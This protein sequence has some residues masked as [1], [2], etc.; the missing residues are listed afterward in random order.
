MKRVIGNI[1]SPEVFFLLAAPLLF[2][3]YNSKTPPLQASDEFNHFYRVWQVSEGQ[4][5][6]YKENHRLGGYVPQCVDEFSLPFWWAATNL[7]YS[8]SEADINETKKVLY[9]DTLYTFKDFPNTAMYSPVSYAPQAL[10]VYMAKKYAK[11]M[12]AIYYAGRY[13]AIVFWLVLIFLSIRLMPFG[14]WLFVLL[15][16]LPMHVYI[17]T[18][19]SADTVTNALAFFFTAY[20]LRI[21]YQKSRFTYKNLFVLALLLALLATAKVVYIAL[22]LLLL[23]VPNT[24]FKN[25]THWAMALLGLFV[26]SGLSAYYWSSAVVMKAYT[27]YVFYNPKFR[28]GVIL[29]NCANYYLQKYLITHQPAYLASVVYR[30][31]T[32]HPGTYLN[33]FIG[34]LG[35]FD[36]YL[37]KRTTEWAYY[38][39]L[40]T[41][42]FNKANVFIPLWHRFVFIA[43]GV[44]CFFLLLLSQHLTWDCVGEGIVDLIQGRYL[45]PIAPLLF[46]SLCNRKINMPVLAPV[47]TWL[48]LGFIHP[49]SLETIYYRYRIDKA[50]EKFSF[51]CGAEQKDTMGRFLTSHPRVFL[52]SIN[53]QSAEVKKSGKYSVMLNQK[54]PFACEYRFSGLKRGDMIEVTA[55]QKGKTAHMALNISDSLLGTRYFADEK[56]WYTN[57]SGWGRRH[58]VWTIKD[59]LSMNNSAIFFVWNPDV[60]EAYLDEL[61]FSIRRYKKNYLDSNVIKEMP[62]FK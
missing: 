16:L 43:A 3:Y 8:L 61:N 40:V 56:I 17:T 58:I 55:W 59:S 23:L 26:V 57:P 18:S 52:A 30:S 13:F 51:Y 14:K 25:R 34:V 28:D 41:A 12:S 1:I 29:S 27:P 19:L 32:E 20:T 2:Y 31:I 48:L 9:K 6:P 62:V 21:V 36:L 38:L 37:D 44:A 10:G 39:I 42:L 5:L 60:K 4:F 7:K 54:N 24:H 53:R 11:T 22:V 35:N 46:L 45:I 15:A 50:D 49:Y 47:S 33:S